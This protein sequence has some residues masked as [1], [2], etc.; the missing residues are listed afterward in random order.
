MNKEHLEI[1]LK[2]DTDVMRVCEQL[3]TF[4]NIKCNVV[5]MQTIRAWFNPEKI[6]A[7]KILKIAQSV[8]NPNR[9]RRKRK[10]NITHIKQGI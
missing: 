5:D 2:A 3:N 6:V 1:S 7:K 8:C 4:S 10:R 9:M